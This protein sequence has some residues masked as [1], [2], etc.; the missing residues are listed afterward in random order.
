M[1]LPEVLGQWP[2]W[3]WCCIVAA[4]VFAGIAHGAIGFGFPLISTPV[5]ALITDV[6][7]AVLMTLLPNIVL[8]FISVVRGANWAATLRAYWP[9]SVY[10]LLGTLVG[11]RV[12]AIASTEFLKLLLSALVVA[13]LLQARWRATHAPRHHDPI[14]YPRLATMVFGATA[15]FFSGTVNVAVPPL[16][17]YFSLLDVAPLVMTQAM[18][19]CFLVGRSTQAVALLASGQLGVGLALLSVPLGVI[20]VA[21]LAVGFRVQ[22]LIAPEH[23]ARLLKIVLWTMAA[24][25]AGQVA[26]LH[27]K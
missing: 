1:G 3:T 7:S 2:L 15:G 16:L 11:T 14:R 5:V 4:L 24:T 12:L 8:N 23:F 26:Y 17:I 27:F 21:S 9:V 10:V 20:S 13:Y 6:R 18:N 25:L 22:A 19:L